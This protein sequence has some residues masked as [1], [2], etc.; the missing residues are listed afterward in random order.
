LPITELAAS[1]LLVLGKI[2]A[3]LPTKAT[4]SGHSLNKQPQASEN[5]LQPDVFR[6]KWVKFY[7]CDIFGEN[8]LTPSQSISSSVTTPPQPI[9]W[10]RIQ[11]EKVSN[12]TSLIWYMLLE[13]DADKYMISSTVHDILIY[14]YLCIHLSIQY[15]RWTPSISNVNW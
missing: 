15:H 1:I 14:V 6:T 10:F 2:V 4:R 5:M 9:L 7:L 13:R 3:N 11:R 8:S 12:W